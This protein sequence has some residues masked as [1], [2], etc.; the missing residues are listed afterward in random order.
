MILSLIWGERE[1]VFEFLVFEG[2]G[3]LNSTF[4]AG[5]GKVCCCEEAD[6]KLKVL[7]LGSN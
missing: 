2:L 6:L 1:R 4:F 5:L 7:V 3:V